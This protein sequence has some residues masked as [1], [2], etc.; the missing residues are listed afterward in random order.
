MKDAISICKENG[1]DIK[2]LIV[3]DGPYK[4]ELEKLTLEFSI[5]KNVEFCGYKTKKELI[6]YYLQSD[7]FVFPSR[8]EGMPNAVL[9]AMIYGLPVIMAPCEG[10]DELVDGNGYV[11]PAGKIMNRVVDLAL[12][13]LKRRQL[14]ANSRFRA[15]KEFGWTKAA[16]SYLEMFKAICVESVDI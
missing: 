8:T 9:E 11:V 12:D 15:E 6:D 1:K 13:D 2:L 10:S 4:Q 14:G 7:I 16:T 3:G 5:D